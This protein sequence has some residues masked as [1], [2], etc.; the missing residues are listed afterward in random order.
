MS[1]FLLNF[2]F[3]KTSFLKKEANCNEPSRSAGFP[4]KSH[5][6]WKDGSWQEGG[7][8]AVFTKLPPIM[9][10]GRLST[11]NL[12][13]K[14]GCFVNKKL[15]FQHEKEQIWTSLN[16]EVNH[17]SPSPSVAYH[18]INLAL[19]WLSLKHTVTSHHIFTSK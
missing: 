11:V 14:I 6:W 8:G 15:L 12:L 19:I 7:V 16:K 10:Q 1:S 18:L 4:G 13:I 2:L 3:Y 17:I 5:S 9:V